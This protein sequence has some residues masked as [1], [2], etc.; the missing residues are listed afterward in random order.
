MTKLKMFLMDWQSLHFR[1]HAIGSKI[2]V[3]RRPG[4]NLE[5][6]LSVQKYRLEED[7]VLIF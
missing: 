2:P 7:P 6:T 5:N 1:K 3:G 4:T